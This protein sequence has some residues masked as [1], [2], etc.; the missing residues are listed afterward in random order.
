MNVVRSSVADSPEY[1]NMSFITSFPYLVL[2]EMIRQK[3]SSDVN[4]T[5]EKKP[6]I[7]S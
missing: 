5:P 4:T 7:M 3:N 1:A 2:P 6:R